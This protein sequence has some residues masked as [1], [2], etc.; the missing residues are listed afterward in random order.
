MVPVPPPPPAPSGG[1]TPYDKDAVEMVLKRAAR[2]VKANC[3]ATTDEDG[4]A[5]GPW[6]KVTVTVKLGHNGH[7]QGATVPA[8]F[9]GRPVGRC[10]AQSFAIMIFPPFAGGDTTV[11]WPVEVV[12]PAG[13]H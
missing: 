7:S 13:A 3:G 2:Q 6:G 9:D 5:T 11:D 4:K 1:G 10:I 8:P 12:P